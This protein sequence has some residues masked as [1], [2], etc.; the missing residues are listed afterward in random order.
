MR[1]ALILRFDYGSVVPW[2][3]GTIERQL[4]HDGFVSRYE[5]VLDVDGLPPGEATFLL[6]SFWLVDNLTLL[7]RHDDAHHLFDGASG[8][9]RKRPALND[10]RAGEVE[11]RLRPEKRQQVSVEL[12]F[13]RIGETVRGSRVDLQRRARHEPGRRPSSR[14]DGHDLVVVAV[15]NQRWHVE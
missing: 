13:V 9:P 11:S 15:N 10:R 12:F 14:V 2:V 8:S 5:T 6:C 1:M 4:T 3:R 7:G